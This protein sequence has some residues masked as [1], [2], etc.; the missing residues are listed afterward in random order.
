[1]Y[2]SCKES[3][4]SVAKQSAELKDTSCFITT[5]PT[6]QQTQKKLGKPNFFIGYNCKSFESLQLVFVADG[7]SGW[8]EPLIPYKYAEMRRLDDGSK[9]HGIYRLYADLRDTSVVFEC[10]LNPLEDTASLNIDNMKSVNFHLKKKS[11]D[12]FGNFIYQNDTVYKNEIQKA[13][14]STYEYLRKN[15]DDYRYFIRLTMGQTG[16]YWL[17]GN[18]QA[19]SKTRE[20]MDKKIAII[21]ALFNSIWIKEF[22]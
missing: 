17:V 15:D 11:D 6:V 2:S 12:R 13:I 10:S 22:R 4:N 14:I 5:R 8:S 9:Y 21:K 16:K 1:M 7:N 18:I 3:T 19:Q 20:D